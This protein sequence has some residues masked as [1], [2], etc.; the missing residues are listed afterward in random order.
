MCDEE[1]AIPQS[2]L[3]KRVTLDEVETQH[4]YH[5]KVFGGLHEA[6]ETLKSQ[7]AEG[8]E[9]WEFSSSSE[10]WEHLAGRAGIALV[11]DGKAIDSLVTL[12][13]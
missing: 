6:W 12:M 10:S 9:L 4:T 5:G 1:S 7:I 11:R 2:W 3:T 13:N 8:D